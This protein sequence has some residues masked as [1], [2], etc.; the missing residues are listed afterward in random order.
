MIVNIRGTSGSGKSTV[1]KE[2]MNRMGDWQA[3]YR[4]GRKKPLYYYSMGD[5]PNTV[6]LGHYESPCGGCDTIGAAP[7]IYDLIKEVQVDRPNSIV[8]C[9]GLILSED[10]RWFSQ[11][12]DLRVFFLTTP[13]KTCLNQIQKRRAQ[14]G[15]H[16]VLKPE[17]TANR[18]STIERSRLKLMELG[19]KCRRC[20]AKQCPDL[21]LELIRGQADHI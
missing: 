1:M 18:V 21:I 19:V 20:P 9:E 12:P 5:W 2:I 16:N 14:V 13:L 4:D 17:N 7:S 11:L 8:L 6:I 15:N 10:S 3:I